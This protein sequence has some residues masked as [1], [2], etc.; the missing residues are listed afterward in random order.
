MRD[1]NRP[2]RL[3][4]TASTSTQQDA[5]KMT[6]EQLVAQARQARQALAISQEAKHQHHPH[7]YNSH[8]HLLPPAKKQCIR[9]PALPV[10]VGEAALQSKDNLRIHPVHMS[11]PKHTHP[12]PPNNNNSDGANASDPEHPAPS[13]SVLE[14]LPPFPPSMAA[15]A[16]VR[17]DQ[18]GTFAM[19]RVMENA[20]GAG[21]GAGTV[22]LNNYIPH[23]H[24]ILF[25]RGAYVNNHPG[26]RRL[27]TLSLERKVAFDMGGH[28]EKRALAVQI[29]RIVQALT[30]P[31]RFLV[32]PPSS[33]AKCSAATTAKNAKCAG[34]TWV[35]VG[36]E[37]AVQKA[38]Q[39]MRDL[40]RSDRVAPGWTRG[41]VGNTNDSRM[42]GLGSVVMQTN[43]DNPKLKSN[44]RRIPPQL[45][46][47]GAAHAQETAQNQANA[48]SLPVP[49]S[50]ATTSEAAAAE[51]II[52][53]TVTAL[54]GLQGTGVHTDATA[55][56]NTPV[57][58][59][60]P[61]TAT[62]LPS[63][64]EFAIPL[65]EEEE[66]V[67]E[68]TLQNINPTNIAAE[69]A[70]I[71]AASAVAQSAEAAAAEYQPGHVGT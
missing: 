28:N 58:G 9:P 41:E 30:P 15:A 50:N 64:A 44:P 61:V 63:A 40:K 14:T 31:G 66:Q 35:D 20:N 13:S 55:N 65:R 46:Q 37:K 69:L 54:A 16:A 42:L 21:H 68:Q 5:S 26:N 70:Q 1:V 62:A 4:P 12:S 34:T 25:G 38:C 24:D 27:R 23:P 59:A 52:G 22:V 6:K 43:V 48:A 45:L 11:M 10:P 47:Q 36:E 2:D 19:S 7:Y 67:Q 29:V 17:H 49:A 71:S 32:R 53:V 33:V 39:V 18:Q 3:G 60:P 51:H 56:S 57:Q 8:S